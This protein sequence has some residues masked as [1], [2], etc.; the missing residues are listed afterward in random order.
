MN[1]SYAFMEWLNCARIVNIMQTSQ[2]NSL[3]LISHSP[4]KGPGIVTQPEDCR[5]E[6][7]KSEVTGQTGR[8]LRFTTNRMDTI[9]QRSQHIPFRS[10]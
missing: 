2:E 8:T 1:L 9:Q 7:L 3:M 5:M 10:R 6:S 4:I